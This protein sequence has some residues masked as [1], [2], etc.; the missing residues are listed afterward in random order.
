MFHN[1]DVTIDLTYFLHIQY[2]LFMKHS[3]W[4]SAVMW[5]MG[6]FA[7]IQFHIMV[8]MKEWRWDLNKADT[9][10]NKSLFFPK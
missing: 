4:K 1:I 8:R 2:E 7:T 9:L 6:P 3:Y 5:K 10:T